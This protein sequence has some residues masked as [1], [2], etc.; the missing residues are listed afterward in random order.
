V[1]ILYAIQGTGNGHISRAEDI[2]PILREYGKLDIFVSGAQAD[3]KLD[4]PLKYKSRGLSFYFGKSGGIDLFKTF[5]QNSS[6]KFTK[7]L[8]T[9][10]QINTTSSSTTLNQSQHGLPGKKMWPVYR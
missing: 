9:F 6:K 4:Y 7:R 2:I 10:R 3:I 1:K 5:K 8:K